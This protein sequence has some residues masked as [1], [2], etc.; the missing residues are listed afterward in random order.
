MTL[1]LGFPGN[2]KISI[3]KSL[4]FSRYVIS[5][6]VR[7]EALTKWQYCAL[8]GRPV[9][10]AWRWLVD[11]VWAK[12]LPPRLHVDTFFSFFLPNTGGF[13]WEKFLTWNEPPT[14]IEIFQNHQKN[15]RK[16][17]FRRRRNQCYLDVVVEQESKSI[18]R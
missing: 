1:K 8:I 2:F 4:Y 18:D 6:V 14:K 11:R 3:Q 13:I 9:M 10:I 15:K 5:L 16:S 12:F 7:A 17:M